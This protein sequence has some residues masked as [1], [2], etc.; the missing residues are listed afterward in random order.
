M[1]PETT[2]PQKYVYEDVAI[3]TYILLLWEQEREEEQLQSKQSFVDLGCGNGLLVHIL[4]GEG[5]GDSRLVH[6]ASEFV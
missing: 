6:M 1:W 3:A 5:V 2:D 4:N